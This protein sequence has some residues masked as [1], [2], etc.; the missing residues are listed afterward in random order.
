MKSLAKMLQ[1]LPHMKI[2]KTSSKTAL[3]EAVKT[4]KTGGIIIFPTETCYGVAVDATNNS[5]VIKLLLFKGQRS[6]KA[7]SIAVSS[8]QMAKKYVHIN[9]VADNTYNNFLPGPI[10]I[11]SKSK[12]VVDKKLTSINNT[13]GI[14]I[15][16][17]KVALDL[18]SKFGRA[19]TATSANSSG[20][21]PPYSLADFKRYNTR[22]TINLT[23]L[24]LDDGP[25][26]NRLPSTI[27]DTTLQDPTIL[28]K[29]EIKLDNSSTNYIS[30]SVE[31]SIKYA[32]ELT[33]RTLKR[34]NTPLIIALQGDLGT[35]KT[36]FT[37]GVGLAI[38]IKETITSPTYT[39]IK[40]YQSG[41][42][43]LYHIDTWRLEDPKELDSLGLNKMF[44][45]GNIIVIEWLEKLSDKL[46]SLGDKYPIL[47]VKIITTAKN[48]RM[49]SH[50]LQLPKN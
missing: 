42:N 38:G 26:P 14:R 7:I 40:Q 28:R 6:G 22:A 18:I 8:K 11:V 29:G 12:G 13:L 41:N 46:K 30:R 10:T 45:S 25:L 20:R 36:Y 32:Q 50:N 2:I 1:Y 31:N 17:H 43:T 33:T 4:L 23:D 48:S 34:T 27:I 15:P 39:I 24:F 44:H 19:I 16:D 3:L 49:I 47:W 9:K 37:K 35:G 21:K 5:A